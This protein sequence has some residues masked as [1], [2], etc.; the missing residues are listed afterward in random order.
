MSGFWLATL[1]SDS[2]VRGWLSWFNVSLTTVFTPVFALRLVHTVRSPR[3]AGLD[4]PTRQRKAAHTVH[5]LLYALTSVVLL[6][7]ILMMDHDIN[8]FSL[9]TIPNPLQEP[10]W[11]RFFHGIHRH[12]CAALFVLV[13]LHVGAVVRHHRAGRAVLLRMT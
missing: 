1:D 9:V 12:S 13:L 3:P 11:N 5:T 10:G 8:V 7:G 2:A 6:S 4:V